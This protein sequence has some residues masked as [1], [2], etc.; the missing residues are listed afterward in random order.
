LLWLGEMAPACTYLERGIVLYNPRQHR[1]LDYQYGQNLA[2]GLVDGPA[3]LDDGHTRTARSRDDPDT[4]GAGRTAGYR[5][6]RV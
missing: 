3:G 4:P 2:S 5:G 1:S 6:G